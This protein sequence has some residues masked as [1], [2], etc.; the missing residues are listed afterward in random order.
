[1]A[2]WSVPAV[3]LRV[4]DGDTF[5]LQLDLGW[6]I[7]LQARCRIAGIN[8]PELKTPA[9]D[10]ALAWAQTVAPAG[11]AVTFRSHSLDKYGRPLGS[12]WVLDG[13]GAG[14]DYGTACLDAGHGVVM[15]G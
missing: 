8:A 13:H 3:V 10:A 12:M 1:M 14:R 4:V 5:L 2:S 7:G 9:G 15:A 6:H 11:T